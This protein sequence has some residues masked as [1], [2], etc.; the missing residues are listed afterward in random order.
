VTS[1]DLPAS[2]G[3]GVTAKQGASEREGQPD[4]EPLVAHGDWLKADSDAL[5]PSLLP[6]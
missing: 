5:A 2:Q 4:T 3:S 6:P 1:T